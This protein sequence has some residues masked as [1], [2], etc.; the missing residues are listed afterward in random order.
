M[1]LAISAG[2]AIMCVLITTAFAMPAGTY[3]QNGQN[4][5]AVWLSGT[6]NYTRNSIGN[7]ISEFNREFKNGT[8][9]VEVI[10][11]GRGFALSGDQFHVINIA[12]KS[13]KT[14]DAAKASKIRD[15]LRSNNS[16]KTIGELRKDVLAIIGEPVYNG[17]IQLGQS[18]YKLMNMKVTTVGNSSSIDA[19]LSPQVKGASGSVAGHINLTMET[20][21]GSRVSSGDLTLNGTSYRVLI[22]MMPYQGEGLRGIRGHRYQRIIGL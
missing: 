7:G 11:G 21:E 18:S 20:H 6:E 5:N 19:N 17:S 2:L 15:L 1:K 3:V 8:T 4:R 10:K 12:I 9:K 22:N 13:I 16:N 14:I